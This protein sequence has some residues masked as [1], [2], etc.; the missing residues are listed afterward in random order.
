MAFQRPVLIVLHGGAGHSAAEAMVSSARVAATR[1]SAAAAMAAGFEAVIVATDSP[2][3]F[4]DMG[5]GVLVDAD[6]SGEAF[7]V[8][9]RLK[10][11]I[12][13]Y[14]ITKPAV[15]GSG[16]VPLLGITEFQLIAE[17]LEQRD[18]RFVTN[19]FFSA[20][21]TAWTP[22]DSIERLGPFERDNMLPRRLRDEGG[23]VPVVLP[24]TTAT[25]FDIDTPSDLCVLALQ[26]GLHPRLQAAIA[27]EALP[28]ERYRR[29][30]RVLCDPKGE[31]VVSGRAGSQA[32]QYLERETACKVRF[33]SEERGMAAA[34]PAHRP[35]SLLGYMVE[36]VGAERLF[37]RL[38]T[39]GDAAIIDTRVIEAHV[40]VQPSRADRF[41]SDLYRPDEISDAFLGRFTAA[42]EAAP[43]PVLLGGHSLVSGG[44]MALNDVAWLENDRR[45][46]RVP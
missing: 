43:I 29:V 35:R 32:W 30:M 45:E 18:E 37:E 21:L 4:A 12:R 42:A 8:D 2:D 20:D 23:L 46:G 40:G 39:M 26:E 36:D 19:N 7:R 1:E 9:E 41:L 15:M 10:G 16:A 34:G 25:Q 11:I 31:L 22:G 33:F 44:L 28:L 13:R 14:G 6:V 17:Q 5:T 3:D 27:P 24:R 38:A